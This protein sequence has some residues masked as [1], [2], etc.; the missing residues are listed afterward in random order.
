[1][2]QSGFSLSSMIW[3]RCTHENSLKKFSS[4]S[5]PSSVSMVNSEVILLSRIIFS[6]ARMI[7]KTRHMNLSDSAITINV[8]WFTWWFGNALAFP[9]GDRRDGW[10]RFRAL[11]VL[12]SVFWWTGSVLEK[13]AGKAVLQDQW[14]TLASSAARSVR[15]R[16][17]AVTGRVCGRHDSHSRWL[18]FAEWRDPHFWGEQREVRDSRRKNVLNGIWWNPSVSQIGLCDCVVVL[19]SH[20]FA[21]GIVSF[22]HTVRLWKAKRLEVAIVYEGF[23]F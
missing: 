22:F 12:F 5:H 2:S 14:H 6:W 16:A 7:E 21:R 19:V 13:E 9:L 8:N 17:A 4:I 1:M 15:R 20:I 23:P 18:S 3:Y 11:K 10:V